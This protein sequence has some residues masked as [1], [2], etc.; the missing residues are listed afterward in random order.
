MHVCG[1]CCEFLVLTPP[2]PMV[3]D[4]W[5]NSLPHSLLPV[6][7]PPPQPSPH[8]PLGFLQKQE[9]A[10][11][12]VLAVQGPGCLG[13]EPTSWAGP[14]LGASRNPKSKITQQSRGTG[15]SLG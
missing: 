6:T 14:A 15:E 9:M 11:F 5:S 10:I 1:R 3:V 2:L 13:M 12:H 7:F 8:F 4:T